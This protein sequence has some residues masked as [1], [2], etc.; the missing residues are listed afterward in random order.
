M[1][2]EAQQEVGW[3]SGNEAE[4][5]YRHCVICRGVGV[6]PTL[7]LCSSLCQ[8]IIKSPCM[9]VFIYST[10]NLFGTNNTLLVWEWRSMGRRRNSSHL[11]IRIQR[12]VH[13][14]RNTAE[15]KSTYCLV[16]KAGSGSRPLNNYLVS[17]ASN[18]T[19]YVEMLCY[20]AFN[21]S[22]IFC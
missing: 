16:T 18:I 2:I 22:I 20:F 9:H 11:Y 10:P 14:A 17:P 13:H 6:Q 4:D 12:A 19:S 3:N 7:L 21:Y 8:Y 15:A 1:R 5:Q